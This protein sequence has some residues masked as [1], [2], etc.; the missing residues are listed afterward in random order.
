MLSHRFRFAML[1]T[2]A[3][4]AIAT[5]PA[6][7]QF[8]A[9][10]LRVSSGVAKGHP[11]SHGITK[12]TQCAAEKS[13]GKLKLQ[14]YYDGALGNDTTASQQV[15]TGSLDMVLTSTAP[16]VGAIPQLAVFDLPF[17]FSNEREADQ[18][19]DGKF[20]QSF[21]PK[22]E[23]AGLVNLAYWENGFRSVTNSKRPVA[24]WEDLQGVKM[25]VMQNK[26]FLDT[27]SALGSNPTPL[28][29]SEVYSALETRTVDGQE[30]PIALIENM[31]FYEVQ[32]F[33]SLT[34]HAYSPLAVLVSKKKFDQLSA[35]E[36]D[37]MRECAVAGQAESRRVGRAQDAEMIA[38]LKKD[39]MQVNEVS[40]AELQRM[41]EKVKDVVQA[42]SKAI[43]EDTMAAVN[44]ELQRIRAAQ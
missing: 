28:A 25:R 21:A 43:G 23:A 29:F 33:L 31:K 35:Q 19:L 11:I 6:H 32:K 3:L 26:V 18:V 24:K 44:A 13:G 27:F 15:R 1:A 4:A 8:E 10:T 38:K 36:K 22:Y 34:R 7:A 9:R 14:T 39:G 17:L 20:G 42:Q 12:M 5:A 40:A 2:A 41:R 37:V 30:N 16:L